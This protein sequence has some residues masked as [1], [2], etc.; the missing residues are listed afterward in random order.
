VQPCI[1]E[2]VR[3]ECAKCGIID[4]MIV[5]HPPRDAVAEDQPGRVYVKFQAEFSAR[6]AREMLNGGALHVESS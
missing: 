3:E 4:A 6:A 2:D 1:E 5:P